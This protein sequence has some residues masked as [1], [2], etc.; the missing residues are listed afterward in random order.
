MAKT[1]KEPKSYLDWFRGAAYLFCR[2]VIG[3]AV[4][5]GAAWILLD[6]VLY[7]TTSGDFTVR[8]VT[9]T[10]THWSNPESIHQMAA[11]N[12]GSN[13]WFVPSARV[14][15]RVARHPWVRSCRVEK[16][17]PDSVSIVIQER[18]PVC[19]I[20]ERRQGVLY[21][22]DREGIVLPALFSPHVQSEKGISPHRLKE[23]RRIPFVTGP[24]VSLVP[25][26]EIEDLRYKKALDLLIQFLQLSPTFFDQL[27][28][29]YI[30]EDGWMELFPVRKAKRI[31][32]SPELPETL[33]RQIVRVWD[34]IEREDMTVDYIDARFPK[35]GIALQPKGLD[36]E[37]WYELCRRN[38]NTN[39]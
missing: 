23:A 17:P 33:P 24:S 26:H 38:N 35:A 19:G 28:S 15:Q 25:G 7:F 18:Q 27:E 3:L 11:V 9:I 30:A 12:T 29:V 6:V 10:G 31:L 2:I 14:A 22:L 16:V 32:L 20:L 13:I 37:R 34:F 21:G 1:A 4:I 5:L 8:E 39:T 36:A